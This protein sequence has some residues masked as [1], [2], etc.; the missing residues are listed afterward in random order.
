MVHHYA[1][2][3]SCSCRRQKVGTQT[4]AYALNVCHCSR[5]RRKVKVTDENLALGADDGSRPYTAAVDT[6]RMRAGGGKGFK[7]HEDFHRSTHSTSLCGNDLRMKP[8]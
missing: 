5:F 7:Q 4:R 2:H 1:I 8:I 3:K 6:T